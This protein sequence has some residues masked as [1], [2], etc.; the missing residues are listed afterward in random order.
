[1]GVR[2]VS[3]RVIADW[4]GHARQARGPGQRPPP[5]PAAVIFDLDGVLVDSEQLWN[6][7]KEDLVRSSGGRWRE[8]APRA[9]MG[10]SS[11]EWAQYLRDVLEVPLDTEEINREVVRRIE[12]LYRAQLP[13]LPGAVDVVRAM[14]D[15]WPLGLASSSNRETIELVLELADLIN[16]FAATV[17]SEEVASGKPAPD[18]YLRTA[19]ELGVRPDGCVAVEDSSNGLRAAFAAGMAVIAVPNPH[20]PP[21]DDALTL[22]AGTVEKIGELT[23]ALVES[24][25]A[26][27]DA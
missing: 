20:Y 12:E 23:P 5:G 1:M 19:A 21:S 25:F 16:S 13:L 15:R 4:P 17:S 6:G 3:R 11:P 22:A 9:M 8:D 2:A 27:A 7:A 24:V 18:V 14:H 26:S 10:M